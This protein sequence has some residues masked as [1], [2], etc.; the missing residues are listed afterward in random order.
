MRLP[1]GSRPVICTADELLGVGVWRTG[2]RQANHGCRAMHWTRACLLA[3]R[4]N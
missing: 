1:D 4:K 3:A 2:Y